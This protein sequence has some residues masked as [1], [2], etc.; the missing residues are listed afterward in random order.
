MAPMLADPR[1]LQFSILSIQEPF[2]NSY[3][4]STRNPLYTVFHLFHPSVENRSV[5]FFINKSFNPS[6]WSGDFLS[7]DYGYL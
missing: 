3:T 5:C 6:T 7:P 2:H 4:N 1:V